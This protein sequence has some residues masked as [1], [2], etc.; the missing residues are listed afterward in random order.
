MAD[1]TTAE[2]AAIL[3]VTD[4]RVR[5]LIEEGKLK[6]VKRGRDYLIEEKSL[7]EAKKWIRSG[8]P[9]TKKEK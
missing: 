1:L 9:T 2:A 5:Q 6:G 7:K 3:G 4:R 8:R